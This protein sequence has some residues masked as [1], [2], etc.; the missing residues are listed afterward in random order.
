[1]FL[2]PPKLQIQVNYCA[3]I[4]KSFTSKIRFWMW[5]MTEYILFLLFHL[6]SNY[7]E[8]QSLVVSWVPHYMKL[9]HFVIIIF[10]LKR[11]KKLHLM[12]LGPNE[13]NFWFKLLLTLDQLLWA[14]HENLSPQLGHHQKDKRTIWYIRIIVTFPYFFNPSSI[15]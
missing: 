11:E 10:P 14:D 7:M 4:S 9:W 5:Y 13:V 8:H 12:T 2:Q 1:M 15:R 6:L 3:D